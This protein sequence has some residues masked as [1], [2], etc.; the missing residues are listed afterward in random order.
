MDA[1]EFRTRGREMVDYIADYLET[2]SS[3]TPLPDIKPGYLRE[4]I[5]DTAPTEGENWDAVMEDIDRVIMPGV[6]HWHCPQFH[7]YYPSAN[8]FPALLGD[9]LS[10]GLG[11]I[12]F[13]WVGMSE[14][15]QEKGHNSKSFDQINLKLTQI[16][17]HSSTTSQRNPRGD[18][19]IFSSATAAN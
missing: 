8:S 11:C 18:R 15:K 9:M 14:K 16:E 6:T 7:A 19:Y 4:L 12:G 2:V 5:P 1:A 17:V 3:R 13:T 10:G